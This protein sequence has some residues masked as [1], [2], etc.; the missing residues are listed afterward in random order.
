M[1]YLLYF[2][3]YPERKYVEDQKSPVEFAGCGHYH[4]NILPDDWLAKIGYHPPLLSFR[5]LG[6]SYARIN[7]LISIFGLHL[8]ISKFMADTFLYIW[9]MQPFQEGV[10]PSLLL[11]ASKPGPDTSKGR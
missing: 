6:K 7:L 4:A 8:F 1:Y 9:P 5:Y 11:S 10:D 2:I 3:L